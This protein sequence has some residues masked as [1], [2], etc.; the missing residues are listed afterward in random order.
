L[1]IEGLPTRANSASISC[2]EHEHRR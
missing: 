2:P 1:T